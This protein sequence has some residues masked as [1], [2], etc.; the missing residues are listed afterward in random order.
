MAGH[1]G[2]HPLD[3]QREKKE[4]YDRKLAYSQDGPFVILKLP[5]SH[6]HGYLTACSDSEQYSSLRTA[7][8][9]Q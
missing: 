8:D 1:G 3:L 6:S 5:H 4:V 2:S 9:L 7:A